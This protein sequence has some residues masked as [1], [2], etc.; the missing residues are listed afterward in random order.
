MNR[1]VTWLSATA[2]LALVAS[3]LAAQTDA[4]PKPV[5]PEDPVSS[6][7]TYQGEL[8]D[9]N[10]PVVGNTDLQFRLFD[11]LTG[12]VQ[13]G[14][15]L[16]L[17]GTPLVDGRFT[18]ELDFGA[19]TFAADARWL[20]IDVFDGATF[21]TLSPRQPITAAPVAQFAL[22]GNAGP[23]GA[24]GPIGPVGPQGLPGDPGVQ[25]PQ[26]LQGLQGDPGAQGLQG[27]PG[28]QGPI[29]P[30]GPTGPTGPQGLQ[31]DPG[32]Q[33]PQGLP[34]VSQWSINGTA[35]FY[36]AGNVGIGTAN[37]SELLHVAGSVLSDASFRSASPGGSGEVFLGWGVDGNG[38]EMARI[39]IGGA[40]PGGTNGLDI[41]RTGDVSLMR[42]Q[43]NGHVG[44]GTSTPEYLLHVV[45]GGS[46]PGAIFGVASASTG[47]TSGVFAINDS[48]NGRGVSGRAS[49]STGTTYGGKF[50]SHSTSGI[51]VSGFAFASTGT[52]VGG[53]FVSNST[54]G[55]GVWGEAT[56]STGVTYGVYGKNRSTS[57]RGVFGLATAT[58]GITDGVSGR[59]D[60]NAGVGVRGLASANTGL[61]Y[62][63]FGCSFSTS[64]RGVYGW[65]D[66]SSGINYG[67]YGVS[68]STSGFDFFAG[69]AGTNYGSSSS[70][71]WK[72]NI[73]PI[74][75]PLTKLAQ[76]RGVYYDW[77]DEHGG[78]HDVGMIAEEVG[79]VLP[80]IVQYEENG[81]DAI[82]MDYSKMTPLLVEAVNALRSQRDS[83]V[84]SLHAVNEALR[85]DN[86]AL[87]DR[88]DALEL[89][90]QH[91]TN[92]ENERP[93]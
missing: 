90:V 73:E 24:Q 56:T 21:V 33:G 86:A 14:P 34:G 51:G 64:G 66:A 23:Q 55:R 31:G 78:A 74:G 44:I 40:A 61:N 70:R 15:V 39:R 46:A 77:D 6:S 67:V 12:G 16:Q 26:G 11:A 3:P 69:G 49:A 42:I 38:D 10:G 91:L 1:F 27:D 88:L 93:E 29:G 79:E 5:P 45:S 47:I 62:G 20:E 52:T 18:A 36:T 65:A 89:L 50:E 83:D 60:S 35:I 59:S 7:I 19:G 75:D 68:D 4:A 85:D 41:Q 71:R 80:E 22:A 82:G 2:A 25:G 72:H 57:G 63:V 53:E 92:D 54:S 17:L 8:R 48:V 87:R 76:L 37:P 30:I 58:S 9:A 84:A 43:H 32:V 13:I 81:I 28:V